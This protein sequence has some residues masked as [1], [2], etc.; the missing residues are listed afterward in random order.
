MRD[1][2]FYTGDLVKYSKEGF[3]S[4]FERKKE[5][6]KYDGNHISPGLKPHILTNRSGT[7]NDFE[8]TF[9]Y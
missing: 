7:R 2:W 8:L 3:F 5:L 9:E 6:L 4:Y 1:G